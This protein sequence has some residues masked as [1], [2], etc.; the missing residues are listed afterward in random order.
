MLLHQIAVIFGIN[1]LYL[2]IIVM[3]LWQLH[4][5]NA[6][7]LFVQINDERNYFKVQY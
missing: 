4:K 6:F 5:N 3:A 7:L 2:R 1:F